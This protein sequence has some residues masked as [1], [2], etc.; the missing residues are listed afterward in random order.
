MPFWRMIKQGY[1]HFEVTRLEPKVDV[2][3]KRYVFDAEAKGGFSPAGKCPA[4]QVNDELAAAVAEKEQDDERQTAELVSRGTPT[5][6]VR[7]GTDGG[8][9]PIFLAAFKTPSPFLKLPGTIPPYARPP[10]EPNAQPASANVAVASASG[11]PNSSGKPSSS[12]AGRDQPSKDEPK[13]MLSRLFGFGSSEPAAA[14]PSGPAKPKE[15]P[16]TTRTAS[17]AKS[18]PSYELSSSKSTPAPVPASHAESKP[19]KQSGQEASADSTAKP[20][21]SAGLLS[22]AQAPVASGSFD[23]RW[24]GV[25]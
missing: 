25:R 18:K 7:T 10:G 24:G 11:A 14:E 1:D 15:T 19:A 8:M 21:N 13:S 22:G 2:C 12:T 20:T 6:P 17:V 23:G 16:R 5:V 4:Y 3:E 9:H